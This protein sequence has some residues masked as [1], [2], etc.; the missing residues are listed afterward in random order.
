[1]ASRGCGS[2]PPASGGPVPRPPGTTTWLRGARCTDPE[3]MPEKEARDPAENRHGGAPRGARPSAEG[4]KAPRRVPGPAASLQAYRVPLHPGRLSALRPPLIGGEWKSEKRKGSRKRKTEKT[5]KRKMGSSEI[6][7]V[8]RQGVY[9]RLR[10]AMG[11]R[12]TKRI[13][14]RARSRAPCPRGRSLVR[15]TAWHGAQARAFAHP[16]NGHSSVTAEASL[17]GNKA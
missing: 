3:E 11:A 6:G 10:R 4:R 16:T 12:S 8:G 1:M 9:A 17:H 15:R 7:R 5:E 2:Q 14:P 13:S